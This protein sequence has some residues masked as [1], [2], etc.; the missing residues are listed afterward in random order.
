MEALLLKV[1]I[2]LPLLLLALSVHESAHAWVALKLGDSTAAEQGRISLY[3]PR[4]LDMMGSLLL[5]LFTLW[6]SKGG[7]A[8]G[9]ARPTPVDPSRLLKPK[10]DYSLVALG[11]PVSNLGLALIFAAA[12]RLTAGL[13]VPAFGDVLG[14]GIT[15]NVLLGCINLLPMPGFDGIKALYVF[16]PDS[17]CWRLNRAE[18]FFFMVLLLGLYLHLLDWVFVPINVMVLLLCG[19]S[20]ATVPFQV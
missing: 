12:A 20:G 14:W 6:I 1:V 7:F 3:P 15:L 17:W 5:P 11:G 4:H 19:W 16:L 13:G 8:Y 2:A 10:R 9:Y 18:P